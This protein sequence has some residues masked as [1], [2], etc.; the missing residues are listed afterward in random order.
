MYVKL[1]G[2]QGHSLEINFNFIV[3]Q[4]QKVPY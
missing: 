3:S 1:S 2:F 4:I